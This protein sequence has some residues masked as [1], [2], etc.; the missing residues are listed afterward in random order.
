[1]KQEKPR[2]VCARGGTLESDAVVDGV[3]LVGGGLSCR[4]CFGRRCCRM[5]RRC[6]LIIRS[7]GCLHVTHIIEYVLLTTQMNPCLLTWLS[8][9]HERR[10]VTLRPCE[11]P[12]EYVF[13]ICQEFLRGAAVARR[14]SV[15]LQKRLDCR[16]GHTLQCRCLRGA[17][18]FQTAPRPHV[19]VFSFWHFEF[20]TSCVR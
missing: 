7:N 5:A 13:D 8:C 18:E 20:L 11:L 10:Q 3:C 12:C 6:V 16:S 17:E 4:W 1:M 19:H 15:C 14:V 2:F 9:V